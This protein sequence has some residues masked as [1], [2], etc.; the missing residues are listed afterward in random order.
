MLIDISSYPVKDML[1]LLLKD[2]TTNKNI[3]WATDTFSQIGI[4]TLLQQP[5]IICPSIEKS[6][7]KRKERASKKAEVSTPAWLCN[8][9]NNLYTDKWFGRTNVFNTELENNIWE[10]TKERIEFPKDKTWQEYVEAQVLEITCGEAPYLVSRYDASTGVSIT[11]SQRIGLLDR[12]IRIVSENTNTYEEWVKWVIK[13]FESSYGYEYQ[14]DNVLIARINLLMTF[15]D[16]YEEYWERW[17]DNKLLERIVDII[18]W[19]IWQ[20]DGLTGMIPMEKSLPIKKLT[21][22]QKKIAKQE[23]LEDGTPCI[24]FDWKHNNTVKFI[25]LA[26]YFS[27]S[28]KI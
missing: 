9:M 15:I 18:V 13:A 1:E 24:F 2:R 22:R 21:P 10:P 6:I 19:N 4:E 25:D 26:K 5:N 28:I 11:L 20:M 17:P 8:K 16:Y 12:K 23:L 27:Y 3:I 7:E 14:G